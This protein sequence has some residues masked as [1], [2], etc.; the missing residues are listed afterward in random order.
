QPGLVD[1]RGAARSTDNIPYLVMEYLDGQ[2]LTALVQAGQ[3]AISAIADLGAQI[4]GALVALHAA[5]VIHCDVKPDNLLVTR[6]RVKVI[7]FGV[8]RALDEPPADDPSIAG[9]RAS[10]A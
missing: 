4:A 3:L 7:D 5:G 6:G 9:T 10:R 1:I 2:T 8:S